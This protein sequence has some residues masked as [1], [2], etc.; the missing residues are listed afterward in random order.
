MV[1]L[2]KKSILNYIKIRLS[3]LILD[4]KIDGTLD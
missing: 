1:K 2:Y 3:E 4:K